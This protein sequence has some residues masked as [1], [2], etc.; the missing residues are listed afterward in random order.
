MD[1]GFS[2]CTPGGFPAFFLVFFIESM[3]QCFLHT[4]EAILPEKFTFPFCYEPDPWSKQAAEEVM[5]EVRLY[6]HSRP[7][8]ELHRL[9]K[10][11]GVLV[12]KNAQGDVFFLKAF[13]A[14]LDGSYHHA[15][16]VPPVFDLSS[17]DGYFRREEALISSMRADEQREERKHRSQALQRWL[18][19]QY[20]MRNALGEVRDLPDIFASSP[21]V[22]S[23][24]EF[25]A[26]K[27][28]RSL[29]PYADDLSSAALSC[30]SG[31]GECCAPKLLQYAYQHQ[32]HPVCMAEFWMGKSPTDELRVEG[33]FYPSC[34]SKC[35]PILSHMLQ[36]L[37]VD[38]NPLLTQGR[39]V[40]GKTKVLYEDDVIL[41]VDKPAGLLSAP[42][43]DDAYSLQEY[44]T[45]KLQCPLFL[46]H[47]LDMDT[48]GIVVLAKTEDAY[49]ALQHQFLRRDVHKHYR[50][51]LEPF[52][53]CALDEKEGVISLPLLPNPLDRPRQMVNH[54]HGKS[55]ITRWHMSEDGLITL[56]SGKQA[57]PVDL[58]P[59]TGRTHQ[60]RVHCAHPDGLGIPIVG[61]RLYG[62][63]ASRLMLHAAE[64]S[65]AH[66]Q[67][68]EMLHIVSQPDW[69]A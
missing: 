32:L 20:H 14:M 68:A 57:I 44:L 42:G 1:E 63:P 45:E 28:N 4:P 27:Q 6:M 58:Y 56:P 25:F 26:R 22:L 15:G 10:M 69:L 39:E 67:T 24:E 37:T 35:K 31:A 30:P 48:S 11:F 38:E 21:I 3:L 19:S 59:E 49:K 16:Y 23:P 9:G 41:V 50:A 43:K 46:V 12:V 51:L 66:P 53:T 61:D 13:S 60:L 64:I 62:T 2:F 18:F 8:S 33:S 5:E 52:L 54:Q 29:R 36:G 34:Q 55:A 47:R 65:F 17:P 7:K 40:A